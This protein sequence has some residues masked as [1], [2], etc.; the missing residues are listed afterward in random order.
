MGTLGKQKTGTSNEFFDL[1][2]VLYHALQGAETYA[3]YC[4][5]AE[6]AGD[7]DLAQFFAD[8]QQGDRQR[9]ERAKQLL[10]RR[11]AMPIS[12]DTVDVG[13]KQSFPA[14]D[15]PAHGAH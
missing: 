6:L 12:E 1:V 14:S 13:S 2:S 10:S 5:D 7:R 3:K 8:V 11:L 15:P 9:A 4:E